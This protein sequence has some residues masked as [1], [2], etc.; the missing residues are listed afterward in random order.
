M[1][2]WFQLS[3][4]GL[5]FIF[6]ERVNTSRHISRDTSIR[7]VQNSHNLGDGITKQLMNGNQRENAEAGEAGPE[8]EISDV[9]TPQEENNI[10]VG[11]LKGRGEDEF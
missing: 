11:H 7:R 1:F 6:C 5:A 9:E 2:S 8:H 3:L 4:K 10:M